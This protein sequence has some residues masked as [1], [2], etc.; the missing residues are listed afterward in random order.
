MPQGAV[1]QSR[2]EDHCREAHPLG[3]CGERPLRWQEEKNPPRWQQGGK[4]PAK[5]PV[6]D[7][8]NEDDLY[9]WPSEHV[10]HWRYGR[11]TAMFPTVQGGNLDWPVDD[12]DH[13]NEKKQGTRKKQ[14]TKTRIWTMF[15]DPYMIDLPPLINRITG[16]RGCGQCYVGPVHNRISHQASHHEPLGTCLLIIIVSLKFEIG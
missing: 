6:P 7:W 9:G 11:L 15:F 8:L 12:Y 14:R 16:L 3:A 5:K 10:L 4:A 1:R 13:G 2:L